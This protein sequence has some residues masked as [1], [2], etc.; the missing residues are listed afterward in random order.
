VEL[1]SLEIP[2][3]KPQ[4]I[5]GCLHGAGMHLKRKT[6]ALAVRAERDER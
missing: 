5:N 4:R 3:V 1:V 2:T 6:I